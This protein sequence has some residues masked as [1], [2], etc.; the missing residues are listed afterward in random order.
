[1]ALPTVLANDVPTFVGA[2]ALAA[3]FSA[4]LSTADA[5]LFMLATSGARDF[6]RGFVRPQAS[7]ADVLRVARLLAIVGCAVGYL[8]T[9][10]FDSVVS[11]LTMFYS[12]LVVTLFAPI[13]GGLYLPKAGRFSALA[14]MLVGVTILGTTHLMTAGL[15]YGWAT[16]PF[17]GLIASGLTYLILAVF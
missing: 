2:F 4:E 5:V 8:L 7:D 13:L 17:L 15:G 6:Y 1:M 11:A 10:V 9:Y 16:P 12:V 14:A 3:V